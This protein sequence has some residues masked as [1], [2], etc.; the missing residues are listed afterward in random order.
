MQTGVSNCKEQNLFPE[1]L[2]FMTFLSINV[3]QR[4]KWAKR[5]IDQ[6]KVI[7]TKTIAS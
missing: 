1:A 3:L 4:L 6:P 2:K 7:I 5:N